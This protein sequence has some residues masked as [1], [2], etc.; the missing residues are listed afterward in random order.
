MNYQ[1]DLTYECNLSC[2][3]C[4]RLCGSKYKHKPVYMSLD[5]VERYMEILRPRFRKRDSFHLMG[6][7]PTLHPQIIDIIKIISNSFKSKPIILVRSNGRSEFTKQVIKN[8]NKLT[9]DGI[10]VTCITTKETLADV[11]EHFPIF[12]S[13]IDFPEIIKKHN[14]IEPY[15]FAI[16]KCWV[17]RE[18]GIGITPFGIF[19]CTRAVAI[20]H[21]LH[22]DIGENHFFSFDDLMKRQG[23]IICK[24]CYRQ[25]R[26]LRSSLEES[27]NNP[28]ITSTW[29]EILDKYDPNYQ[30]TL[31]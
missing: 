18:C 11:Q 12:Q 20:A 8:I 19:L 9:S 29:K 31:F 2:D 7:E 4:N 27:K 14:L 5:Q 10:N 6:G 13:I 21:L 22:L 15:N 28:E 16:D 17:P 24:Y 25:T 23:D 26:E 1:I 30:L 3:W